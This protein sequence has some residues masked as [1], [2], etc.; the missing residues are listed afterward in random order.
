MGEVLEMETDGPQDEM[1]APF[2]RINLL[3]V[4]SISV[5]GVQVRF[6]RR[7]AMA[8]CAY[9]A[10]KN[11]SQPRDFLAEFFWPD[12]E[13]GAAKGELRKI[14]SE[15]NATTQTGLIVG[16]RQYLTFNGSGVASV[17]VDDLRLNVDRSRRHC[18]SNGVLCDSCRAALESAV[19]VYR[20]D[21]M[22]GFYLDGCREFEEWQLFTAEDLRRAYQSA[23]RKLTLWYESRKRF[24]AA[25]D[26]ARKLV[27]ADPLD[28]SSHRLLIALYGR[29]GD[30]RAAIAQYQNCVRVL[31][32]ELQTDPEPKT[33][34]LYQSVI[35]QQP[36][37]GAEAE[38]SP[39]SEVQRAE[40]PESYTLGRYF[41]TQVNTRKAIERARRLFEFTTLDFPGSPTGHVGTALYLLE[42]ITFGVNKA[43]EALSKAKDEAE[44]AL[45][46]A[47]RDATANSLRAFLSYAFD[48]KCQ[49]SESRF[50]RAL[51][52]DAKSVDGYLWYSM[53]LSSLGRHEEAIQHATTA[54]T[55][56][57]VS[58]ATRSNLASVLFMARQYPKAEEQCGRIAEIAPRTWRVHQLLGWLRFQAGEYVEAQE[59]LKR[60]RSLGH[61]FEPLYYRGFFYAAI[62]QTAEAIEAIAELSDSANSG[63][64]FLLSSV[65]Y[66]IGDIAK[67][68]ELLADAQRQRDPFLTWGVENPLF[69]AY[70]AH[71]ALDGLMEKIRLGLVCG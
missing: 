41:L 60:A 64:P 19:E 69:D 2:V 68:S 20:D 51:Q 45:R 32:Q 24:D 63:S 31:R 70:R 6:P 40:P 26:F 4:P 15:V 13:P 71:P 12:F 65:F 9:L 35:R 29:S 49:E 43:K 47:P 10:V 16:D 44:A 5:N 38:G 14:V 1:Q 61:S 67:A 59:E 34:A 46:I 17:D 56:D 39:E 48:G 50:L 22:R 30:R 54:L 8:L 42:S 33:S 23:L 57:P 53:V 62:G 52:S 21:F 58:V 37:E 25:I 27:I 28:E 3:G 36:L 66:A 55:L 18:G 11:Q 7:K